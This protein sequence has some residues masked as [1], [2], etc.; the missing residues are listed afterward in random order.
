ML[1]DAG[2]RFHIK[3]LVLE[4]LSALPD[5]QRLEWDLLQQLVD[6]SPE[7]HPHVRRVIQSQT[8]W[9]D[10]IDSSGF[11]DAALTSG[12]ETRE[13]EAVWTLGLH[14]TLETRS[15][16]AAELLRRH[17][18]PDE[19]WKGY[20][21]QVCRTGDVYHSREMFDFF[22]SLID[23]GTLDEAP[24]WWN[25]LY[26]MNKNR[27][28]LTCKAI[29]RWFDRAVVRWRSSKEDK[30]S[31]SVTADS[32]DLSFREYLNRSGNGASVIRRAAR[33]SRSCAEQMLPRVA[34]FVAATAEE[35]R[36]RLQIDPLWFSRSFGDNQHQ[37]HG[38]LLSGLATSLET[39]ATTAPKDLD[40]LLAPYLDRNHDTIAFLVLRAW[41][42]AP[43]CYA[44][45]LAEYI[46]GDPRRLKVGYSSWNAEGGSAAAYVSSQAVVAA[47][48]CSDERF[49]ALEKAI[50]SL[51]DD[52]EA[53]HPPA[54]GL[55]Q[56]EM[57]TSL[58][59]TRLSASGRAKL[60]ELRRKF[61]QEKHD[62]PKAMEAGRVGSPI[63]DDAQARMS[64]DQWL[65]AMLKYA[66]QGFP[67]AQDG[68][69]SGGGREFSWS[70]ESQTKQEPV[71]FA[72]LTERMPDELPA[73]YFDAVVN[74]VADCTSVTKD[75]DPTTAETRIQLVSTRRGVP[76]PVL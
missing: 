50:V 31:S 33:S 43:E 3:R 9:F 24:I 62:P 54:R 30:D 2:I 5:P 28:D 63:P 14:R 59:Q 27:P 48:R 72:A 17:R 41:T 74:G 68:K 44:D 1:D 39:L 8:G 47:S 69:L 60:R 70:V 49:A 11:F 38:A 58:D 51:S 57:L 6:S 75:A 10:V 16:R 61:P 53:R 23:D 67:R 52:W 73:Y 42:A 35:R 18:K 29:A 22:L 32:S 66:G 26:R 64:D 76:S 55:T 13:Q 56:L 7:L 21:H 40:R 37:I 12:D 45:R 65:R 34:D 20:L 19:Q 25:G 46:A 15:P 4:W 71:R 36:D